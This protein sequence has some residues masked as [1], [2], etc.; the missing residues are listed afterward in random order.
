MKPLGW[1][2]MIV[3]W[4]SLAGMLVFCFRRILSKK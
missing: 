1:L 3:S 4:G 2:F